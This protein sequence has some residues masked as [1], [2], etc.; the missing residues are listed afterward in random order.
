MGGKFGTIFARAGHLSA[1][2]EG[3]AIEGFL[4]VFEHLVVF[5]NT[6]REQRID[7]RV[8]QRVLKQ[9]RKLRRE[10]LEQLP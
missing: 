4:P 8:L 7:Q 10:L 3:I 2:R 9:E 5:R 1:E 6:G